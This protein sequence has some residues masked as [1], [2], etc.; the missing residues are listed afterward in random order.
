[1]PTFAKRHF[2]PLGDHSSPLEGHHYVAAHAIVVMGC[3]YC[4]DSRVGRTG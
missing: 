2:A 4:D 1:M 3:M